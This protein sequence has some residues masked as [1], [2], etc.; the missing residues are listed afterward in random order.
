MWHINGTLQMCHNVTSDASHQHTTPGSYPAIVSGFTKRMSF[1]LEEFHDVLH[2]TNTI[3][4]FIIFLKSPQLLFFCT[5]SQQLAFY[6]G[7][8]SATVG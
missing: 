8:Q 2:I 6:K 3:I 4:D 1:I 5:P 7:K